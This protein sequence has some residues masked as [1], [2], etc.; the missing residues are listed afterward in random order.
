MSKTD[1]RI[2]L[3]IVMLFLAVQAVIFSAPLLLLLL[4]PIAFLAPSDNSTD[5]HPD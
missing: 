2:T 1:I 4:V 5:H 3:S